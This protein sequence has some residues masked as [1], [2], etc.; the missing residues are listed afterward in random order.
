MQ[1]GTSYPEPPPSS[2]LQKN[3]NSFLQ[4]SEVNKIQSLPQMQNAKFGLMTQKNFNSNKVHD[5]AIIHPGQM[6]R[7]QTS[8]GTNPK[9]TIQGNQ[10]SSDV[11]PQIF[12]TKI[13]RTVI[14]DDNNSA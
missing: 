11:C 4:E 12:S 9:A 5:T 13:D 10:I 14:Q 6:Q 3:K 1:T 8:D 7:N 2:L